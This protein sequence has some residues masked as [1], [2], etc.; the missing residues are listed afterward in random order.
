MDFD[1]SEEQRMWHDTVHDFI[2]REVKPRA[3]EVD[4]NAEFNW[5]AVGKMAGIGLLGLNISE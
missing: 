3:R 4:E 5:G 2:A 1:L